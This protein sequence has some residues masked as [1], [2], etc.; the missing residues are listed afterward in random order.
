MD[1]DIRALRE[2]ATMKGQQHRADINQL[3][4]KIAALQTPAP[5]KRLVAT[6]KKR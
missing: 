5:A 2:E 3:K 6:R 1:S 4:D